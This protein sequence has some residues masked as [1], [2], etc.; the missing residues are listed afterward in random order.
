MESRARWFI[1]QPSEFDRMS[2]CNGIRTGSPASDLTWHQVGA[3]YL[4]ALSPDVG[5]LREA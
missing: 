5:R 2:S 3:P 4:E 1:R